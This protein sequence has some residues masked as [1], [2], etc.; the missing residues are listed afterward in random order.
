MPAI[1]SRSRSNSR[2]VHE[3]EA[4]GVGLHQAVLDAVVN[5]LHEVARAGRADVRPAVRAAR[6]SRARAAAARRRSSSPPAIRQKPSF[7]APDPARDAD[8]EEVRCPSPRPRA[9]RRCESWKFELPPSTSTSPLSRIPSSSW[10]ASSV[11]SPAGIIIQTTRGGSSC[12][13]ELLERRRGRLDLRVVRHHLVAV[14]PRAAPSSRSPS[15]RDRP[16]RASLESSS[17]TRQILRPRSLSASRS[18]AACAAIS[19]RKPNSR[20][21]IVE[22]LAES[23]PR[24]GRRAP[25]SGRPCAAGR[26]SAGS[27]GRGPS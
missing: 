14:L 9:L 6:A 10:I 12:V 27:A 18:P 16:F 20:P 22:L 21:G 17:L 25:C 11:I 15:V 19:R 26:S 8:V 1:C 13:R 3:L 7:E 2:G 4:L 5:H 23:R 24:P